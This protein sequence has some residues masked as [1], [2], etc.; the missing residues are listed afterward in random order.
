[1]GQLGLR[2]VSF[3]FDVFSPSTSKRCCTFVS[4][5][6]SSLS[7][8]L[9]M[10]PFRSSLQCVWVQVLLARALRGSLVVAS[11]ACPRDTYTL[12][13]LSSHVRPPRLMGE[14]HLPHRPHSPS[15]RSSGSLQQLDM[16]EISLPPS[17]S[18]S[19]HPTPD[20]PSSS[21]SSFSAARLLYSKSHVY[22]HPT[23]FSAGNVCG[24]V[25][26]VEQTVRPFSPLATCRV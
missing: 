22:V 12:P 7:V 15:S 1:M 19:A 20:D 13:S 17:P 25:S 23:S 8:L 11:S 18:P 16:V 24:Y 26:I 2:V 6:P 14:G 9:N 4:W 10:H 5:S 3:L 21:S